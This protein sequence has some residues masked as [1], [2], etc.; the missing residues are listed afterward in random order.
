MHYS[1]VQLHVY[2][3]VYYSQ[4]VMTGLLHNNNNVRVLCTCICTCIII[5]INML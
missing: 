1:S 2:V 5:A 4:Y 3:C